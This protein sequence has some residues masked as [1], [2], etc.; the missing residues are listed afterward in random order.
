MAD[1]ARTLITVATVAGVLCSNGCGSDA[2]PSQPTTP[3]GLQVSGIGTDARSRVPFALQPRV[4]VVDVSGAPVAEAGISIEAAM[5]SGD[6]QLLGTTAMVTSTSGVAV[7]TDLAVAGPVGQKTLTFTSDGIGSTSAAVELSAGMPAT[8]V[9]NTDGLLSGVPGGTTDEVPAVLVSD[10]D[11]NPVPE[12]RVSFAVIEGGGTLSETSALTDVAG[13]A[14]VSE[15]TLGSAVGMNAVQAAVDA[16][17][18]TGSPV[19]FNAYAFPSFSQVPTTGPQPSFA[20]G[21][22][23]N[24]TR[25]TIALVNPYTGVW[26]LDP[27][28]GSWTQLVATVP[29]AG[30]IYASV[31]EAT[32]RLLVISETQGP[33]Y[34]D[35]ETSTWVDAGEGD[36]P[37]PRSYPGMV[38][39]AANSRVLLYGGVVAGGSS[40]P[41]AELFAWSGEQWT[42]LADPP[43]GPRGGHGMAYDP[44]S[45]EIFVHGGTNFG[46]PTGGVAVQDTWVIRASGEWEQVATLSSPLAGFG[47]AFEETRRTLVL[48]GGTLLG[49]GGYG[50]S[51]GVWEL[52][53]GS[54]LLSPV[55]SPGGA[56]VYDSVMYVPQLGRI[57][58]YGSEHAGWNDLWFYGPG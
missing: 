26:E 10:Q 55:R 11:D 31:H 14:R 6:G 17:G 28:G 21:V 19:A 2:G 29:G 39:D 4:Q 45:A 27:G 36:A 35:Y 1:M 44:L 13:I 46:N 24:R 41:V 23:F 37:G 56:R 5:T 48:V 9:A 34:F 53:N 40:N 30:R 25:G 38:Y 22:T 50:L 52:V 57:V 51:D 58:L 33:S 54:W 32:Q 16:P 42:R 15:W 3:G 43:A 8:V 47:M 7:Y 12:V 49:S 18:V 20:T